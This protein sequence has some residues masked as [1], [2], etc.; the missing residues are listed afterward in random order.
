MNYL[1]YGVTRVVPLSLSLSHTCF[2]YVYTYVLLRFG[3]SS[4]SSELS[5]GL[6]TRGDRTI[7][8]ATAVDAA[9]NLTALL[10]AVD[11]RLYRKYKVHV[12]IYTRVVMP[13]GYGFIEAAAIYKRHAKIVGTLE[14]FKESAQVCVYRV[15][16][17]S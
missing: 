13:R 10:R 7:F 9:A 11:V 4:S 16:G 12:Y 15:G 5:S 2:P 14:L 3:L 6:F 8:T 17:S 1:F